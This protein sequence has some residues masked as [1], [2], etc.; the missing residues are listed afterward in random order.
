MSSPLGH[1]SPELEA[2][3]SGLNEPGCEPHGSV[4][5]TSSANGSSQNTGRESP[6]TQTSLN[7]V[8]LPSSPSMSC[9]VVFPARIS[10]SPAAGRDLGESVRVFGRST[11]VLLASFDPDGLLW[12]TSQLCLDGALEPF[13][14]TW[15]R[16]GMTRSGIAYRLQPSA[17]LTD[18][19]GSGLLPTPT[20][21]D[22]KDTGDLS[23]VPEK[24]L[25]P[26][27][28]QRVERE[29]WPTPTAWLG[30]RPSSAT[31]DPERFRDPE[32]S[33][34]LSDAVAAS[35]ISGALNPTWVEWLMG[36]PLGW[37]DCGPSETRSSRRSRSGSGAA[38]S[39][40][41]NG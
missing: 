11:P 7:F 15:P 30:R 40:T 23:G 28:G 41:R 27:D 26:R 16:S 29:Q 39:R 18:V 38:S 33:N 12:R 20:A 37:T 17:P 9:A 21:R 25:L 35:G 3:I 31:G 36:F 4:N 2:S 13:S 19:T 34:E 10:V 14:G 22:W 5:R 1:S 24:S 6:V 8:D 32:R